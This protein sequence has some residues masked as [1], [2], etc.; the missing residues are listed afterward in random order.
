MEALDLYK[1]ET[2]KLSAHL[3]ECKAKN[4]QVSQAI[5]PGHQARRHGGIC[6][7]ALGNQFAPLVSD[8]E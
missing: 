5:R 7:A 1:E 4:K 2:A 8:Q 3:A 6:G